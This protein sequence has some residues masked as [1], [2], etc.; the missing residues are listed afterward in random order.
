MPQK[1]KAPGTAVSML[2]NRLSWFYDLRGPSVSIDTACSS[3][4]VAFHLAFQ[5]LRLGESEMVSRHYHNTFKSMLSKEPEHYR[6]LQ[7]YLQP[8]VLH[9]SLRPRIFI[10]GRNQL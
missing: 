5:S 7:P 4:L 6:R 2:A 1:Y 3:S 10:P 9:L 8:G